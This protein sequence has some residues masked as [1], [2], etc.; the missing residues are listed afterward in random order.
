MR[1]LSVKEP[2]ATLILRHGKDTENRTWEMRYRGPLVIHA[3]LKPDFGPRDWEDVRWSFTCPGVFIPPVTLPERYEDIGIM[4]GYALGIVDVV[5]CDRKQTSR[6]D[7]P[8]Q[9]H[10]RLANPRPFARPFPVKGQLGIFD[11][12]I[13]QEHH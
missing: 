7:M 2:W 13:P 10:I 11:I 12:Q 1:A 5:G 4:P 8:Y 3:S 6:W 9:W